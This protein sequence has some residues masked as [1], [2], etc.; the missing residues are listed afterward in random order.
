MWRRWKV[1]S[2][3]TTLASADVRRAEDVLNDL[4]SMTQMDPNNVPVLLASA[5]GYIV[6]KQAPKAR[7][8][9]KRI[10]VL[11]ISV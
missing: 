5:T 6:L 7:N 8:Q 10:Q 2:A 4:M 3:Y 11:I 1:H 9:L